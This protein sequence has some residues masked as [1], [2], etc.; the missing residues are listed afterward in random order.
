[1]IDERMALG[2]GGYPVPLDNNSTACGFIETLGN[3]FGDPSERAVADSQTPDLLLSTWLLGR[4]KVSRAA[5][6]GEP[7]EQRVNKPAPEF[8]CR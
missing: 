6:C 1:M 2:L 7:R 5:R 4:S 8:P 3:L